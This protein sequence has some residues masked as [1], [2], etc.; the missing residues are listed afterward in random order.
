[1]KK[2]IILMISCLFLIIH[3]E[4]I[5]TGNVGSSELPY[6]SDYEYM[7]EDVPQKAEESTVQKIESKD[8][9]ELKEDTAKKI[10]YKKNDK[11]AELECYR[12]FYDKKLINLCDYHLDLCDYHP[13][14]SDTA[15]SEKDKK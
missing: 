1:M 10:Q 13:N 11:K 15:M 12:K 9:E 7:Y 4:P 2:Y 3:Y 14:W 8:K 5:C 6:D